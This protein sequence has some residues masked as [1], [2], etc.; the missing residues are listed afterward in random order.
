MADSIH[1]ALSLD[2]AGVIPNHADA[3]EPEEH[4]HRLRALAGKLRPG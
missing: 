2:L 4:L 3:A 1:R